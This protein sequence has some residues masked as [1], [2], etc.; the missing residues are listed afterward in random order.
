MKVL[1]KMGTSTDL[2]TTLKLD[3]AQAAAT[4]L[5]SAESLGDIQAVLDVKQNVG[6]S[7]LEMLQPMAST[8]VQDHLNGMDG[9]DKRFFQL[10]KVRAPKFNPEF[11]YRPLTSHSVTCGFDVLNFCLRYVTKAKF[12]GAQ[13]MPVPKEARTNLKFKFNK[14]VELPALDQEAPTEAEIR[15]RELLGL[16]IA[17]HPAKTAEQTQRIERITIFMEVQCYQDPE[18]EGCMLVCI[19]PSDTTKVS[20]DFL[21]IVDVIFH[22]TILASFIVKDESLEVSA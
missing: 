20:Q 10:S 18:N 15:R 8:A 14:T 2:K 19:S 5:V 12:P 11:D 7:V 4:A 17:T 6:S 21:N 1:D 3:D 9:L 22:E 16:P 13:M